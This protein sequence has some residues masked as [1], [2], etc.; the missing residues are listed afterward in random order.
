MALKRTFFVTGVLVLAA[1]AVAVPLIM[2]VEGIE[3]GERNVKLGG[4][5]EGGRCER[6]RVD[7]RR[8]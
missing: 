5:S 8:G 2:V 6:Q 7:C 1:A 3:E 4:K